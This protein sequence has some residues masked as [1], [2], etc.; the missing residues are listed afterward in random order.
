MQF[1]LFIQDI[2]IMKKQKNIYHSFPT[3]KIKQKNSF[4]HW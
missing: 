1:F 4:Q 3:P 2:I